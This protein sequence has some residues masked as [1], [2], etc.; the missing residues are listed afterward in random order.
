MNRGMVDIK[1]YLLLAVG[2]A[3]IA[4]QEIIIVDEEE[5]VISVED[6]RIGSDAVVARSG[7]TDPE[8]T[9]EELRDKLKTYTKMHAT[10]RGLQIPGIISLSAGGVMYISGL[11]SL[12]NKEEADA[13]FLVF[14]GYVGILVGI[15]LTATGSVLKGIGSKKKA[16][17]EQRLDRVSLQIGVNS[18]SLEI[19]F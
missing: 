19:E 1:F 15:P 7:Y 4:A 6:E 14:L 5:D 16:E 3:C 2:W 13:L 10:G 12:S 11:M 18:L 9:R 8:Y 17:Y